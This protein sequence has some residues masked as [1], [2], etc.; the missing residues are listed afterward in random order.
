MFDMVRE[1]D[2]NVIFIGGD[3]VH[4]KTQGISPELIDCLNWWFT[5]MAKIAPTHIILGNHDGLILNKDRQDA[6]TPIVNA[7]GNP[8][9]HLYKESG[10][11]PTGVPGF[12]WCVFSCFDEEGWPNVKPVPGE[13]NI[14]TFH[15]SVRGSRTDVDWYLEADT[16]LEFFKP[17]DFTFLGDIHKFQYMDTENRVAYPGSTIQQNFG[18][19]TGK[20][21]L[22]WEI[23]DRDTYKSTFHVIPH[24]QPYVTIE[25]GGD[26]PSTIQAAMK[27]PDMSRFRIRTTTP[28]SHAEMKQLFGE[29]RGIKKATEIV[30]KNDQEQDISTISVADNQYKPEDLRTLST[31]TKLMRDFYSGAKLTEEEWK[32][33]E[34]LTQKYFGA[35][36]HGDCIR[37]IK[38]SIKRLEFDNMFSYGKGN[39]INFDNLRGITG[40]FG[41]NRAGKSSIPGTIMY[42][43]YNSTDRGAMSN[44]HVINMRKGHCETKIDLAANGSFYRLE[45]QSVR[46]NNK[47]GTESA[48]TNLNFYE[49]DENGSVTKDLNGEQ[50]RETEKF[51][52]AVVGTS[53]DFLLTSLA[54]QGEMNNFIRHKA[55]ARKTILT[56]FLDLEIFDEMSALAKS[57][58]SAIKANLVNVPDRDWDVIIKELTDERQKHTEDRVRI[59]EDLEVLRMKLQKSQIDLATLGSKSLVTSQDVVEKEA[60][61]EKRNSE[62]SAAEETFSKITAEISSIEEKL[63]SISALKQQFP[64]ADL[65]S[66]YDARQD[67]ERNMMQMKHMLET[68][69]SSIAGHKKSLKLLEEVPCGDSFPKC[70]FIKTSHE[71]KEHLPAHERA[72]TEL[73]DKLSAM[74]KSLDSMDK[75]N[76]KEKIDKYNG[77]L[78]RERD[79]QVSLSS[80]QLESGRMSSRLMNLKTLIK[81]LDQELSSMKMRVSD[82]EE[83]ERVRIAKKLIADLTAE[84]NQKDASRLNHAQHIGTLDS[85]IERTRSEKD[86]FAKLISDWRI[87]E[88]FIAAVSKNGIPLKIMS[89][90]LPAINVEIAKILQGVTGFTVELEADPDTNEMEIYLNYG[91]SKRIIECG[92][93]MEKMMASL[94]IRV[95]LINTT[96]LPK[97][98]FLI[99]DEGFGALD[100]M[101]VEACTRLLNSLKRWFKSI[102]VISHVDA[103]KDA[104]DNVLDIEQKDMNARVVHE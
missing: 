25:W 86:K 54:S 13:V 104:V 22:F 7:L 84:V 87:Y 89:V 68:E 63:S 94:A 19:T 18:E 58:A 50:R 33:L 93:G 12:N 29:L 20:G 26:I 36:S 23:D 16:D 102:L 17:Y 55:S 47:N 5:E 100:D 24:K 61:L 43:L 75:E 4:S 79:L 74:R 52:R 27:H 78:E 70:K 48:V 80:K 21:F 6:I 9:L 91:D 39:I 3:I 96:T 97:S 66:R 2:P 1:M 71:S 31:H 65:R 28:I 15:G 42:G 53:D 41:R 103:V 69:K 44:L 56:K 88:L 45:R 51:L 30:F 82:T 38:W 99:I 98:D 76:L 40:I 62:L 90:Q 57:D 49:L 14:A 73:I 59:E 64:I 95:A 83:A 101:N 46:K 81:D 72:A 60:E 32:R 34:A 92:S 8:R 10:V 11:Y 67:L 85:K 37:N 35:A 77:V